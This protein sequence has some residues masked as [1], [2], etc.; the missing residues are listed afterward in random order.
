MFC[1]MQPL[2]KS[3]NHK[4]AYCHTNPNGYGCKK[5]VDED[6]EA[7]VAVD[8][9]AEAKGR[10]SDHHNN[11]PGCP[12]YCKKH[13]QHRSCDLPFHCKN[14]MQL[15]AC[16]MH[17]R[18]YPQSKGCRPQ[19]KSEEAGEDLFDPEALKTAC[20]GDSASE[21]CVKAMD[22]MGVDAL[23]EEEAKSICSKHHM[24]PGCPMYCQMNPLSKACNHKPAYCHTNPNG[25]GCK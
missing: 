13:Q 15:H 1:K 23:N 25:Y 22:A 20:A 6:A 4:P 17:C 19:D 11:L 8:E 7:E 10:C 9:D 21:S 14:N 5:S 12:G 18:N 24:R 3:C 2:H 16:K